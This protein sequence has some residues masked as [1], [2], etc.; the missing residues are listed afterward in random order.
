MSYS[1]NEIQMLAQKAARGGGAYAAQAAHFGLA[2]V[3]HLAAGRAPDAL[4]EALTEALLELPD[5]PIQTLPFQV[6]PPSGALGETYALLRL[7]PEERTALP[8]RL[9]VPEALFSLMQRLA[10]ETYVPSS[11]A[12][13]VAGAGAGL[14]DN[15]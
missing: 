7:P 8:E 13:R 3:T 6:T 11:E 4:T 1:V 2:A 12:S 9:E 15:D 5:G 14:S 10:Q